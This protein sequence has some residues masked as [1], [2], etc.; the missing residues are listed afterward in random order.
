MDEKTNNKNISNEIEIPFLAETDI[1]D[2]ISKMGEAENLGQQDIPYDLLEKKEPS[3][4]DW[5]IKTGLDE[6]SVVGVV[7]SLIFMSEKP[8]PLLKLK[9]LI[10]EDIPLDVVHEA[11]LKLQNEYD[12]LRHG[13]R[14]SE[15][16]SGYQFRTK[17]S[18][19]KFIQKM[20]KASSLVLTPQALEVLAIVAYRSP[21]SRI[22]IDKIRGVDSSHLLRNLIDKKLVKVARKA[23]EATK[24]V[25][26]EVSEDFFEL[27]G[28]NSINDLPPEHEVEALGPK[29]EVGKASD[30]RSFVKGGSIRAHDLKKEFDELD[31]LGS[32]IKDISAD[33]IFT[34]SVRKEENKRFKKKDETP[35]TLSSDESM[36]REV[37]G[38]GAPVEAPP[39]PKSAFELMEEF[40]LKEEIS[41]ENLKAL[42]VSH[43]NEELSRFL[44]GIEEEKI[45]LKATE[46]AED[47]IDID[48]ELEEGPDTEGHEN[49]EKMT[50]FTDDMVDDEDDSIEKEIIDTDEI[51][52][53]AKELDLDLSFLNEPVEEEKKRDQ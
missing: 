3:A 22:D 16:A 39:K 49:S 13:I 29:E 35:L 10:D 25:L 6:E 24:G 45:E 8:I 12:S 19:N 50:W 11:I 26:Y 34:K 21:L 47:I 42:E 44:L 18:H 52:N 5:K 43:T 31:N 20:F 32:M 30:I 1:D 15:V 46:T 36:N 51:V 33:T 41:K 38:G 27:F 48:E 28:L 17:T 9:N 2:Y 4:L 14:P 23:E 40:I 37:E 53:D 7:E